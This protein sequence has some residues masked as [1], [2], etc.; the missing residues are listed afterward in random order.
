ML[1]SSSSSHTQ[2][3]PLWREQCA[4]A[5]RIR[6][7]FGSPRALTYV[8]GQKLLS[9][10]EEFEREGCGLAEIW[11]FA[12]E[13]KTIFPAAELSEYFRMARLRKRP[14]VPTDDLRYAPEQAQAVERMRKLLI[15]ES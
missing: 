13:V 15:G 12:A 5:R 2:V 7:H 3:A 1:R 9:A 4:A 6:E 10:V 11:E 14:G 8:V